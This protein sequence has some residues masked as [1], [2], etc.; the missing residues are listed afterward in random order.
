MTD[1]PVEIRNGIQLGTTY[2]L[3]PQIEVALKKW[4]ENPTTPAFV[5]YGDPGVGKTTLVYRVASQLGFAVKEFNASHTRT[6]SAFKQQILPLLEEPGITSWISDKYRRGHVVLL[7]EMDGMSSGERGGLQEL[8]K[9]I[10]NMKK[11]AITIPLICCC[12][13]IQGRKAQQLLRLSMVFEVKMPAQNVLSQWLGRKLKDE[14]RRSDLR[15][16]LRGEV[17]AYPLGDEDAEEEET[18]AKKIAHQ[19]LFSKWDLYDEIVAET[20]DVNL[21]SLLVH[22]NLLTRIGKTQKM[23]VYE[24]LMEILRFGDKCDFWAFFHQCWPLLNISQEFKCKLMN[25]HLQKIEYPTQKIPTAEELEYTFV[26]TKQSSLFNAWKEIC[27]IYDNSH[28]PI[29][30][31][32]DVATQ[33]SPKLVFMTPD[34]ASAVPAVSASVKPLIEKSTIVKGASRIKR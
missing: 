26:L 28:I 19:T 20:K 22:Q 2:C 23:E 3:H 24:D 32:C 31:V 7:D 6:G 9:Y 29:H 27:Q 5:M 8:L 34:A 21:A 25:L 14:E 12:N 4:L 17:N 10:R 33:T 13:V 18:I 15:Q 30:Y 11:K 1:E 16:L